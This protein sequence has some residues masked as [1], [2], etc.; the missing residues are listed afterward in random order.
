MTVIKVLRR[1]NRFLY[2][3]VTVEFILIN[4][5]FTTKLI[6]VVLLNNFGYQVLLVQ[7]FLEVLTI[8]LREFLCR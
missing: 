7:F 2:K 3:K 4:V 1:F 8:H 5:N 6:V